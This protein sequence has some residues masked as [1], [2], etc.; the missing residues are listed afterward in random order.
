LAGVY[1]SQGR[2]E[3]AEPLIQRA[4]AINE[5]ALGPDHPV[6]AISVRSYT[7]FLRS[8]CRAAEAEKLEARFK[9]PPQ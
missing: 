9:L 2:Y 1:Y 5:K 4:L 8:C 7:L 3:E 6:T